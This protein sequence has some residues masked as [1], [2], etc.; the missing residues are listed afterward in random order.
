MSGLEL[1]KIAAAILLAALIGMIGGKIADLLYKPILDPEKRGYQVEVKDNQNN[2]ANP[3]IDPM[4][5]LDIPSLMKLANADAGQQIFKKCMSCHTVNKGG[6]NKVGP[7]LWNIVGANKISSPTFSYSS[8]MI[9]KGGVWN[10]ESLFKFIHKPQVF[11][12]GT[13]MS[14]IGLNNP[15]DI[16]N[17]IAYL[18]QNSDK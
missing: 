14:F 6:I 9:A 15:Q 18:I 16:A 12:P 7:N 10:L 13:K 2:G 1:N 4:A 17:V 11:V 8:A 5:N 3:H